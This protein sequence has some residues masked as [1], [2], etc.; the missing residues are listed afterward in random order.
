MPRAAIATDCVDFMLPPEAIAEELAQIG[1][2]PYV[3]RQPHDHEK[4]EPEVED[5]MQKILRLLR[6]ASGVDFTHYKPNTIQRRD[7]KSTRL[8]SSHQIISYAVF[9]LKK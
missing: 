1:R 3:N 6:G 7:R 9:C 5:G 8:N 2:H 4:A